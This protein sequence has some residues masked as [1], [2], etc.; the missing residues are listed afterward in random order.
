MPNAKKT[1]PTLVKGPKTETWKKVKTDGETKK[2]NYMLS[3]HGRIKSVNKKTKDEH[4]IRGTYTKGGYHQFNIK[5]EDDYRQTFYVHRELAKLFLGKPKKNQEYVCHKDG[6]K[7]NNKINN[8]MWATREDWSALHRKLG[9]YANRE[10]NGT[11]NAKLTE[12]E[13]I[14]IKKSLK[15]G[16]KTKTA[17]AQKY[18][19][20]ITQI[21]RISTGENWK[22][23]TI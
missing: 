23:V 13:V 14:A 12:K 7:K 4:L 19:V 9:T 11:F 10:Y 3:S 18:G 16:K 20:S 2:M 17:I 22:H 21:N 1:K 8:L 15:A 5:L 6:D